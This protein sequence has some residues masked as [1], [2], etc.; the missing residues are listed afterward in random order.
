M[1][2]LGIMPMDIIKYIMYIMIATDKIHRRL[3]ITEMVLSLFDVPLNIDLPKECNLNFAEIHEAMIMKMFEI[4]IRPNKF[5]ATPSWGGLYKYTTHGCISCTRYVEEIINDIRICARCHHKLE[6]YKKN[7]IIEDSNYFYKDKKILSDFKDLKHITYHKYF[8]YDDSQKKMIFI[9]K[10]NQIK[11][12]NLKQ[13]M[14][15]LITQERCIQTLQ[16]KSMVYQFNEASKI[17][18]HSKL[19]NETYVRLDKL[20]DDFVLKNLLR[21]NDYHELSP[22]IYNMSYLLEY[23]DKKINNKKQKLN[24]LN[25]ELQQ[26]TVLTTQN[27]SVLF[28]FQNMVDNFVKYNVK[29]SVQRIENKFS[30]KHLKINKKIEDKVW[31]SNNIKNKVRDNKYNGKY[32]KSCGR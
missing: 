29:N 6:S 32:I 15:S 7:T 3:L 18:R 11:R 31:K 22:Y 10:Q 8:E 28:E 27:K 12:K 25:E 13:N 9:S 30:L 2:H 1:L 16:I 19:I 21:A 14:K 17:W 23:V 24:N 4:A 5:Q 20:Y 26:I